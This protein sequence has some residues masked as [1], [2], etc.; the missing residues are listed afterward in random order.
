MVIE[1]I[2]NWDGGKTIAGFG[3]LTGTIYGSWVIK[4]WG[5][6]GG[7]TSCGDNSKITGYVNMVM[8]LNTDLSA[9]ANCS[10]TS[11]AKVQ[12]AWSNVP[13]DRL[14]TTTYRFSTVFISA[15][16]EYNHGAEAPTGS[17]ADPYIIVVG[18]ATLD[19]WEALGLNSWTFLA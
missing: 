19:T 15:T 14:A 17:G 18:G 13:V 9:S 6:S 7:G 4:M 5:A 10:L 3:K 2:A 11:L 16:E 8:G 1:V 12:W